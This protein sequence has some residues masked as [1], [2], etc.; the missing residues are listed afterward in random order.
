MGTRST[1][2]ADTVGLT[3]GRPAATTDVPVAGLERGTADLGRVVG[4]LTR[5]VPS[6][7]SG[8][9][10]RRMIA[11]T[12]RCCV[13]ETLFGAAEG[14]PFPVSKARS[15]IWN[16]ETTPAATR[17]AQRTQESQ[18]RIGRIIAAR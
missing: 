4:R 5:C 10:Q 8:V 6:D 2:G 3:T 18:L 15:Q 14:I 7:G 9:V 16:D 12:W 1:A 17:A 13:G 11:G